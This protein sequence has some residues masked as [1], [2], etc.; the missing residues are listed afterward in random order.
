MAGYDVIAATAGGGTY[1]PTDIEG[2]PARFEEDQ[3][4]AAWRRAL[5]LGAQA[6]RN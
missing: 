3:A 1:V 2:A 4:N 5:E 6:R